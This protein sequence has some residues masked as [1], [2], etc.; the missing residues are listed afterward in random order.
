MVHS[1]PILCGRSNDRDADEEKERDQGR[2][3]MANPRKANNSKEDE[4]RE[5]VAVGIDGL[6]PVV[7][8]IKS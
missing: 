6:T 3:Q 8:F 5:A 4:L 1:I 2:E 7:K